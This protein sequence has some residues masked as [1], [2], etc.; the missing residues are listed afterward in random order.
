MKTKQN[1]QLRRHRDPEQE[2]KQQANNDRSADKCRSARFFRGLDED[3]KCQGGED[4][5]DEVDREEVVVQEQ[6][7]GVFFGWDR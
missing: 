4:I 3:G 1:A 2:E 7:L 6:E 5:E